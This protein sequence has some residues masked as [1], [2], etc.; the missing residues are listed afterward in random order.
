MDDAIR[1]YSIT[2]AALIIVAGTVQ[3]RRWS[4]FDQQ[5]RLH[6]QSTALLNLAALIG[7]WEA[8]TAGYPGG[9]R[10][11]LVAVGLT[12]LLGAV[13]LKPLERWRERRA[14]NVTPES[15]SAQEP[16]VTR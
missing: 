15:P 7:S 14:G 1:I 5:D 12:W 3:I 11:Y 10:I 9:F 8:L 4:T 13:L 16:P 6:W 2:V